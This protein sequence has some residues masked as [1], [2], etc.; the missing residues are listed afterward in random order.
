MVL[1]GA[2]SQEGGLMTFTDQKQRT[3][4]EKDCAA[5]WGGEPNGER[6]RC[7]LCGRKFI[8][9]DKW[10]W[11]YSGE[12]INFLVCDVCDGPDVRNRW[13]DINEEASRRF[14]WIR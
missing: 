10:R 7:Y 2:T 9:G 3:A 11:V 6:F 14:W 1:A 13:R 5:L 4:T 8:I 12:F